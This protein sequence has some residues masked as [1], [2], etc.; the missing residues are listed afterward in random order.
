MGK[1]HIICYILKVVTYNSLLVT[2]SFK[3]WHVQGHDFTWWPRY[4]F[5]NNPWTVSM[6]EFKWAYACFQTRVI[7]LNDFH[8]VPRHASSCRE[9]FVLPSWMKSSIYDS[10]C[11]VPYFD[12]VNHSQHAK[13]SYNY[14]RVEEKL[15]LTC[16]G[17]LQLSIK[18]FYYTKNRTWS[19]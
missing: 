10:S 9:N 2:F 14:N 3:M 8:H 18:A 5:D 17:S 12:M 11:L 15:E 6:D 7:H 13:V 4:W 16:K 1:Q 19:K